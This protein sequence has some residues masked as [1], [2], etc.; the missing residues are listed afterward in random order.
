M[1][2]EPNT[3]SMVR[4]KLSKFI[5]MAPVQKYAFASCPRQ[6]TI[7]CLLRHY[8]GLA[9]NTD[10]SESA[11]RRRHTHVL[12]YFNFSNTSLVFATSQ[13]FPVRFKDIRHV[14]KIVTA[15]LQM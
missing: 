9:V 15:T 5:Y 4:K 1:P 12:L 6:T 14:L 2:P 8:K 11:T 10:E 13:Q 7:F 3:R